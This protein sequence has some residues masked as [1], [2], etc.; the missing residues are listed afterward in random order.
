MDSGCDVALIR[1]AR[2]YGDSWEREHDNRGARICRLSNQVD[3][4]GFRNIP[5]GRGPGPDEIAV[6]AVG[7]IAAA[8]IIP[9]NGLPF[10]AILLYAR[11][12][13]PHPATP[14]TWRGAPSSWGSVSCGGVA[15]EFH[16]LDCGVSALLAAT[17]ARRYRRLTPGFLV[18]PGTGPRFTLSLKVV[19]AQEPRNPDN[20]FSIPASTRK[21][22]ITRDALAGT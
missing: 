17:F 13:K 21:P 8:R 20:C 3:V 16:R 15:L 14:T 19:P 22:E 6:S 7:T 9:E 12:E 18:L 11:W 1:K 10:T 2:L 5:Q 4:V